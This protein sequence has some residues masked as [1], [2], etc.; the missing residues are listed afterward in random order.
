MQEL[1]A[2]LRLELARIDLE[3]QFTLFH[4]CSLRV[5]DL[6]QVALHL[7]PDGRVIEPHRATN[8]VGKPGHIL[9]NHFSNYHLRRLRTPGLI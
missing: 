2:Q 5:G 4:E 7:G 1:R 6:E 8:P 3:E 9:L